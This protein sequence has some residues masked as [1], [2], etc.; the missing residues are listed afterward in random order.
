VS[1][2]VR[3]LVYTLDLS[4]ARSLKDKRAV[5]RSLKDRLRSQFNLSVAETGHQ[6]VWT[7]AEI[8]MT[9]VVSSGREADRTASAIDRFIEETSPV[10]ILDVR[11]E[12]HGRP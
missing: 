12:L 1:V 5:V 2:V 6:D 11:S 9:F 10:R 8:A 7:R 3:V 4:D